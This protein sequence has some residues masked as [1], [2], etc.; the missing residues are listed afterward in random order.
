MVETKYIHL[1][2]RLSRPV[3]TALFLAGRGLCLEGHIELV[4][5]S[6][7]VKGCSRLIAMSHYGVLC[8][9]TTIVS[10]GTAWVHCRYKPLIHESNVEVVN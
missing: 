1:C 8:Y 5:C 7:I 9:F 10:F 2:I 4:C 6:E 3:I